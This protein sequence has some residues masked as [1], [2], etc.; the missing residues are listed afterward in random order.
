MLPGSVGSADKQ[1]YLMPL[2][3]YRSRIKAAAIL[4]AKLDFTPA[5]PPHE[6]CWSAFSVPDIHI[7]R[8]GKELLWGLNVTSTLATSPYS[9]RFRPS[10]WRHD[11]GSAYPLPFYDHHTGAH[12]GQDDTVFSSIL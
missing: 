6:W 2:Q 11:T 8:N 3:H 12:R 5:A 4:P 1:A 10:P 7:L 9:V